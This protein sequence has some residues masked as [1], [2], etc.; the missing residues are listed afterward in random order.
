MPF[1]MIAV[2]DFPCPIQGIV[3]TNCKVVGVRRECA[4]WRGDLLCSHHRRLDV[5]AVYFVCRLHPSAPPP[6][7]SECLLEVAITGVLGVPS[8]HLFAATAGS[9]AQ[10][11]PLLLPPLTRQLP[12]LL[13]L[14]FEIP[15]QR[16][17]QGLR[18]TIDYIVGGGQVNDCVRGCAI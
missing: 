1:C 15:N 3:R 16:Q 17:S 14:P 5:P 13:A 7:V 6:L 9:L 4:R 2:C 10:A 11:P 8:Q 18:N 12:P